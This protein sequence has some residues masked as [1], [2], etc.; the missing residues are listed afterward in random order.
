MGDK[1]NGNITASP[2]VTAAVAPFAKKVFRGEIVC[3]KCFSA[4]HAEER[5][6]FQ[7]R[8]KPLRRNRD[9]IQISVILVFLF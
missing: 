1:I 8:K 6:K 9:E 3:Q 5:A 2:T 4:I 7:G